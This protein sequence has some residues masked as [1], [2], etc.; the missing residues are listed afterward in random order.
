MNCAEPEMIQRRLSRRLRP[1]LNS[2]SEWRVGRTLRVSRKVKRAT[3]FA[4]FADDTE[5]KEDHTKT[6]R[7]Q[8]E[9][10]Q[11]FPLCE[12]GGFV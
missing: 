9:G 5:D 11:D 12:V 7:T 10:Q 2:D 4:D 1:T 8:S 6:P 3:D